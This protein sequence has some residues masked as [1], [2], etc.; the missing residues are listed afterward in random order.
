M[1]KLIGLLGLILSLNVWAQQS[2]VESTLSAM[3]TQIMQR[4]GIT[5]SDR[6]LYVP[7]NEAFTLAVMQNWMTDTLSDLRS[8]AVVITGR[9]AAFTSSDK[10]RSQAIDML[11]KACADKDNGIEQQ[12][13][14][15]LKTIPYK[16]FS[17]TH[18]AALGIFLRE[19]QAYLAEYIYLAG[20]MYASEQKSTLQSLLSSGRL[21]K[22]QQW[23][24]YLALARLGSKTDMDQCITIANTV[25]LGT[26]YV[27][28][29]VPSLIYTRQKTCVD[30][31]V[32]LLKN[33][34]K[35]CVPSNPDYSTPIPCRYR[36]VAALAAAI[37]DFPVKVTEQGDLVSKDYEAALKTS[38]KWFNEHKDYQ[39]TE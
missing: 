5:A 23:Q 21:K 16:Y 1:K 13:T 27:R 17:S 6:D 38:I 29:I 18:K 9:L 26:E 14:Q 8:N 34:E 37:Q 11:F 32:A 3:K 28:M 24:A 20:Y 30:V 33:E 35:A 25:P 31:L 19:D 36:I 7:G 15:Y 22:M 2:A 39:F 12:A 10:P 4:K